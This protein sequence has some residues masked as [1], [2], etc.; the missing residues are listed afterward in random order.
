MMKWM[1]DRNKTGKWV[2][3]GVIAVVLLGVAILATAC[4]GKSGGPLYGS[5]PTGPPDPVI[6][7]H[8]TTTGTGG[9]ITFR[10]RR[11]ASCDVK[12]DGTFL[13]NQS[14]PQDRPK[15]RNL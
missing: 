14:P 1:Y 11:K 2:A 10:L 5:S 3:L 15:G 12:T 9:V 4:Y 13:P 6:G 7:Q 8:C